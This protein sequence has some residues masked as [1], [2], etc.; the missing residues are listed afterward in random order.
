V[1]SRQLRRTIRILAVLGAVI[2]T[3]FAVTA[4]PA[5]LLT[6]DGQVAEGSISGIGPVIRLLATEG[7]TSTGPDRQ[8]DIP[9]SS[10]RQITVDFPRVVIET[11]DGALIGPFS[12]FAGISEA[13]QLD[14]AG[15]PLVTL[16]TSALRAIALNGHA[17]RPVP[18]VWLGDGY[19]SEP[20]IMSA[21]PFEAA[22]CDDCSITFPQPARDPDL[23]PIWNGMSPE[24]AAPEPT[25]GLPWWVGLLVV[26]GIMAAVYFLAPAGTT[27]P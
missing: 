13:L 2:A 14:R 12:A 22:E 25:E 16:P 20:E 23:I 7:V 8:F 15:E 6:N 9:L 4:V 1:N 21:R 10:I 26:G 11:L 5:T 24:V 3:A 19:L 17:L 27:S 18:R